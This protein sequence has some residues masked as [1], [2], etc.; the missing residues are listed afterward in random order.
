MIKILLAVFIVLYISSGAGLFLNRKLGL[1]KPTFFVPLGFAAYLFGLQILYYPIQFFYLSSNLL[2]LVSFIFSLIIFIYTTINIK[3]IIK[4]YYNLNTIFVLIGYIFFLFILYRCS[5]SIEFSD[6]QPYLNYITQNINID[7]LNY[8]D[9]WTGKIGPANETFYL[10]QG[11]YHF[12]SFLCYIVNLPFHLFRQG[13]F[14]ENIATCVWGLG[15]IY[16]LVSLM[17][18]VNIVKSFEL[19]NKIIEMTLLAFLMFYSN[20]YYWRVAFAFYGNTFRTL[21]VA[22]L[23]FY[24]YDLYSKKKETSIIPIIIITGAG[25][26]SSSS[27]LFISFDIFFCVM[28]YLYLT[29]KENSFINLSLM[30][31]PIVVYALCFIYNTNKNL[32][33]PLLIVVL[34]YYLLCVFFEAFRNLLDK[35]D[36]FLFKYGKYIFFVVFPLLLM[37]YSF[38]I[39]H[40]NPYYLSSYAHYFEDHSTYDMVID[41]FNMHCNSIEKVLNIFRWFGYSIVVITG[42]KRKDFIS[43]FI[44]SA[45]LIFLNPLTTTAIAKLYSDFVYYRAFDIIFNPFTESLFFVA[46]FSYFKDNGIINR[47]LVTL[48]LTIIVVSHLSILIPGNNWSSY[49]YLYEEGKDVNPIFKVSNEEYEVMMEIRKL[50]LIPEDHQIT[51]ISQVNTLKVFYPNT[52]Q[53]F[54]RQHLFNEHTRINEEFFQLSRN[55]Y[56]WLDLAEDDFSKSCSYI[57]KYDVDLAIINKTI[58]PDFAAATDA[59]MITIFSLENLEV[60]VRDK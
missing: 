5:I 60:K 58:N 39:N 44:V 48:L 12:G 31:S 46:V 30:V 50:G 53:I 40:S 15:S 45:L 54:V 41:Y 26:A 32:F 37:A 36:L 28:A 51:A 4:S 6:A 24:L 16:S 57:E 2:M 47:F 49:Y 8:F 20:F 18:F 21:F 1:K 56:S 17:F 52:Y 27:F 59:C 13:G 9:F 7:K 34:G 42:L 43:I 11:Y 25:L 19:K 3:A 22:M 38:Y 35:V 14:V 33:I 10:Y 55:R 23:I 29:K